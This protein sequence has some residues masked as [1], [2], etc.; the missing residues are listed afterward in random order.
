MTLWPYRNVCIIIIIII[1]KPTMHSK[2]KI[3]IC[4]ICEVM[5]KSSQGCCTIIEQTW[6]V[7]QTS[8]TVWSNIGL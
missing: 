1:I 4:H 7:F 3:Q 2:N 6:K 8:I 5:L